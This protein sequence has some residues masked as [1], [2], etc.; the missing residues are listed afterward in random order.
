MARIALNGLG[1]T[2][3]LALRA[4]IEEGFDGEIALINDQVGDPALFAHL[5]EFDSVHGRWPRQNS[6]M[7]PERSCLDR[8]HG[9]IALRP[10]RRPS[11]RC[12]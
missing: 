7:T 8:R 12:R 3:K 1:R 9:R 5:L 2:G 4:L 11:R 6:P 10:R